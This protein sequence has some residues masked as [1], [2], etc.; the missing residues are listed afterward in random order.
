[1]STRSEIQSHVEEIE[2]DRT[3][4]EENNLCSRL[5]TIDFIEFPILDQLERMLQMRS[6]DH[7]DLYS[8]IS[9]A[10]KAKLNLEAVNKHLFKELRAALA[11]GATAH[12]H[13]K[14]LVQLFF[15]PDL[16]PHDRLDDPGYDH[17]DIFINRIFPSHQ[18]PQPIKCLEPEMVYY[19][20]TP[21]RIIFEIAEKYHFSEED[22][23][24]DVGSGTG[25]A[26]ILIHLLTGVRV[27]GIEFE[28]AYFQ[29]AARCAAELHLPGVT[30]INIDARI[31]DYSEG[32]VFYMY[33]PF[34]GRI[35]NH[36]LELLKEQSFHRRITIIGYGPCIG[37]LISQAWLRG[38]LQIEN[39]YQTAVFTSR[40]Q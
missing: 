20:K 19:Q 12:H 14:K 22:I 9:R 35:M 32:T 37:Q 18:I 15:T 26:A 10:Q 16:L 30:F 34:G 38:P 8:L 36:V 40:W 13:F 4:L 6:A 5:D 2:K 24:V 25:Q 21:A 23:F 39:V 3:L 11:A 17:L 31:A 1:M 28:P 29:Y 33:T 7:D 27:V